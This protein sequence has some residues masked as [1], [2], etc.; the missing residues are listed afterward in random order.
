M[1]ITHLHH[2]CVSPTHV[3]TRLI[4]VLVALSAT[5]GTVDQHDV[6]QHLGQGQ[7]LP[8]NIACNIHLQLH[9]T[10]ENYYVVE[11]PILSYPT[12]GYIVM[13]Y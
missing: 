4:R 13:H 11:T 9:C 2:V 10:L 5:R 8:A 6:P 1:I 7:L 3:G 12:F